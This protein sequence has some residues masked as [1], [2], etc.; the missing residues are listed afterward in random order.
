MAD[1]EH[2]SG[3]GTLIFIL[4]DEPDVAQVMRD[5]LR[6]RMDAKVKAFVRLDDMLKDEDLPAVDL[7]ILDIQLGDGVSG[8]DVPARLSSRL[9]FAAFLFVSGYPVD[10]GQYDKAVGL[11]FFDFISKPFPMVH[12]VHR[13]N[14]LLAARLRLPVDVDDPLLDLWALAPFVAVVL[15]QTFTIRLVNQQMADLLEVAA[16]RD[17]VGR[18]W[19]EFLPPEIVATV[20]DVQR[21][22]LTG[23]LSRFGE[24]SNDVRSRSG[25]IHRV[26]WFNSPFE[27]VDGEALTLSVGVPGAYKARMS[28]RLRQTWKDSILK[29]RAAI[30]AIKRLPRLGE[31]FSAACGINNGIHGG[32]G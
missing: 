1:L 7:F 22:V 24:H 18:S 30:Q 8:F 2:N 28:A 29:H 21:A 3:S 26:K 27:G 5:N 25:A 6:A 10:R 14:L 13:V 23:D 9:R 4:D 19:T 12:F 31:D 17:L 15:D 20:R 16:A 32:E 11:P